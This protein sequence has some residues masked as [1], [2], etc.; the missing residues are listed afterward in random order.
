MDLTKQPMQVEFV[1]ETEADIGKYEFDVF[2]QMLDYG[3][4]G[5]EP[6]L[7]A[8]FTL[9]VSNFPKCEDAVYP[10]ETEVYVYEGE[11]VIRLQGLPDE[12]PCNNLQ[13]KLKMANG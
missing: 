11:H 12:F 13:F 9:I 4:L 7:E 8:S 10:E 6:Y 2:V 5:T 1:A 3:I